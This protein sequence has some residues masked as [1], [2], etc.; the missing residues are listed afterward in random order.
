MLRGILKDRLFK[1]DS[2]T[3]TIPLATAMFTFGTIT[4][5]LP[6][7][8]AGA[9]VI[10]KIPVKNN[11]TANAQFN[12]RVYNADNGAYLGG[13]GDYLDPAVTKTFNYTVGA[14]PSHNWNLRVDVEP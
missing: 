3:I 9:S 14:M 13:F 2:K 11:G 1:S 12:V 4:S 5:V 8:E 10:L 6:M 7:Y